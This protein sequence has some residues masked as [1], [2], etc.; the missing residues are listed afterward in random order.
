MTP[1]S[2][3]IIK[4]S[5]LALTGLVLVAF[6]I[7]CMTLGPQNMPGWL[8]GSVGILVAIGIT[9]SFLAAPKAAVEAA[10]DELARATAQRAWAA[11]YWLFVFAH[12]PFGFAYAYAILSP[13]Q[14]LSALGTLCGGLPL[15]YFAWLD[16]RQS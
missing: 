8:P 10:D 11:G 3:Q 4:R 7:G 14:V 12:I 15:L 16:W 1:E 2:L 5:G 9:A 6:A 13:G